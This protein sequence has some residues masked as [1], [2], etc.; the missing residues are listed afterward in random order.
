MIVFPMY[1]TAKSASE[2][3]NMA[4]TIEVMANATVGALTDAKTAMIY[5]SAE[6]VA[7]RTVVLQNRRA[8]DFILAEKGGT[9]ALIEQ[10]SCT[11]IPDKSSNITD[12]AAHIS[13]EIKRIRKVSSDRHGYGKEYGNWWP[14]IW[15]SGIWGTLIHCGFIFLLIIALIVIIK[16]LWPLF[17]YRG[18]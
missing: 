1:G 7:I 3:L 12:L 15:V 6:M 18:M 13:L 10:E 17:K 14:F 2:L 4:S 5:L 11:Y 16:C 8:L 9:Y